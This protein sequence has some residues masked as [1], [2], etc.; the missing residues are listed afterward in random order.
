MIGPCKDCEKRKSLCHS[1]CEE[2]KEWKK[3]LEQCKRNKKHS[4]RDYD[5]IMKSLTYA[6]KHNTKRDWKWHK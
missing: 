6:G 4:D 3:Y 5:E 1:T 2:Y